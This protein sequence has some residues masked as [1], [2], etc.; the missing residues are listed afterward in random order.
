MC[1][2][3]LQDLAQKVLSSDEYDNLIFK[4][5]APLALVLVGHL[6][7]L[8]G[9]LEED[10]TDPTTLA[11]TG[12]SGILTSGQ[13]GSL[14]PGTPTGLMVLAAALVAASAAVRSRRRR[15]IDLSEDTALYKG[16]GT[17]Y[18]S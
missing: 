2:H 5:A 7:E 14:V 8:C 4:G 3:A 18:G 11:N 1:V 9:A 17:L 6:D 16:R 15:R 12:T 13:E 10:E